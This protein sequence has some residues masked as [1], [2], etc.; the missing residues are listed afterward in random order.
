[1]TV[2][3]LNKTKE[4][5]MT[6]DPLKIKV[7]VEKDPKNAL[8][9][10]WL[11]D[12]I[13]FISTDNIAEIPA[14]YIDIDHLIQ[15]QVSFSE[16]KDVSVNSI[17]EQ[18]TDLAQT[19]VRTIKDRKIESLPKLKDSIERLKE[20]AKPL[21]DM[22]K[23]FAKNNSA[24]LQD[25]VS[26]VKDYLDKN[27]NKSTSTTEKSPLDISETLKKKSEETTPVKETV[28]TPESKDTENVFAT[29]PTCEF[30][31]MLLGEKLIFKMLSKVSQKYLSFAYKSDQQLLIVISEKGEQVIPMNMDQYMQFVNCINSNQDVDSHL[32][33][34]L[35]STSK[36]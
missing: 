12:E 17:L 13:K 15:A 16:P 22:L 4:Q 32:T 23:D 20:D 9:G 10:M 11:G 30:T 31:S 1:M 27:K 18:L 14:Q 5:R 2:Y 33:N 19:S 29:L 36:V 26:T 34:L 7:V 8:G 6:F 3:A 21:A 24:I 25:G 28:P 35:E